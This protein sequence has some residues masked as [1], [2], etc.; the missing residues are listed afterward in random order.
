MNHIKAHAETSATDR[1]TRVFMTI[2]AEAMMTRFPADVYR[3]AVKEA[4][5][6]IA[7]QVIAELQEKI[8]AKIN[9]QAIANLVIAESGNSIKDMLDKKL[10][11][12]V[13]HIVEKQVYQ[14]GFLGGIR[15]VA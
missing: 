12:R 1:S 4:A 5:H 8:I 15:R 2:D 11:D 14:R 6:V 3:E 10:P 13:E 9:Q 7:E